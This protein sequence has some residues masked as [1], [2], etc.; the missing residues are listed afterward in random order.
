MPGLDD[1]ANSLRL[2]GERILLRPVNL[3][4]VTEAYIAWMNDPEVNRF[5]E[6]RFKSHSREVIA[7]FVRDMRADPN[8]LFFAIV[9][10]GETRH[11][12]NIK[13]AIRPEHS[14]GEISLFIGD[15]EQWGRGLATE[16]IS[17]V[18]KYG[19]KTIGVAKLTAGCYA[20]NL[21][22]VRAFENN[23]FERDALL[24][25]EYVCEGRRVDGIR[26]ACFARDQL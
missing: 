13:L 11:I 2:E 20:N 22:S 14:R 24:R 10:K 4:D 8:I 16:A 7:D 3:E 26:F 19:L 15:K 18:K 23:G 9:L 17:L 25:A 6:T 1:A 5:M 21:G 12:G